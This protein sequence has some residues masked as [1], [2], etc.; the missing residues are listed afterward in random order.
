MGAA[1]DD[2]DEIHSVSVRLA[3]NLQLMACAPVGIGG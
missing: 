3:S 1:D 2:L